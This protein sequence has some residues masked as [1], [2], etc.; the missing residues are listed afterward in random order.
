MGNCLSSRR[1][2]KD[3]PSNNGNRHDNHFSAHPP[4]P[5]IL[6][7]PAVVNNGRGNGRG[8]GSAGPTPSHQPISSS[9]LTSAVN[10]SKLFIAL[11]DYEA[12]TDEDLSFKKGNQLEI[13]NDTQGDWWF[14]RSLVTG[15]EGF[16][17]SNYIAKSKSLESEP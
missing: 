16:I 14:A 11:Y 6:E 8:G 9:Q 13:L 1:K 10:S 15:Q 3:P 12:R 5:E 7:A 17:P 4:S 2:Y